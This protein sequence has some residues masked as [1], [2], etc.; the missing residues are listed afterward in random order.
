M[1]LY[2]TEK[3]EWFGCKNCKGTFTTNPGRCIACGQDDKRF[4]VGFRYYDTYVRDER[5]IDYLKREK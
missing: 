4:S 3:E 1:K 2:K 5:D